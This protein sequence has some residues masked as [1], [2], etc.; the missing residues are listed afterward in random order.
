[1]HMATQGMMFLIK[2]LQWEKQF[3]FYLKIG[4]ESYIRN[5]ISKNET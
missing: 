5:N 3:S 2:K 1:M 4:F